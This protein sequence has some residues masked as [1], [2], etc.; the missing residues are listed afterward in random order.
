MPMQAYAWTMLNASSPW[1]VQFSSSGQYARHLVRF[2]LSGL[3]SA[4]DLTVKLDGK[5]L[6]WT[7]RLDIGIDR[8]HYDI[9]RQ[10]VLEDGLHELS[11]QL[12]NN[13][14]EGTAQLCS[15]EILEFGAPNEFISTPGHYSL[16]PTFSETNTTSY[17]PTNEDCLMRI[18]TTPN[19]CKVCL[20]GLW[21][22]LLRRVDFIDSISTSCDQ[23]GVSPPRFNRVLDLKLV[24]LGQFRL[25]ADDLEAGNK[26][27]AEEYS[28]TWY[29]DGEVLEE[30]VNQT[31]IE[32]NDG[33]GQ[34]VGL[35]S[36][37]VK[38]TTTENY[39]SL[40]NPGT[41]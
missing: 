31:H 4:S 34:G 27:P 37:E 26:I 22:S 33:D 9:H 7:P 24:P 20:E 5:D 39:R 13:Q 25:P 40:V 21:L 3:P 1:R 32:V 2:S 30:F 8:W 29:K 38:F 18:V 6:R 11:F 12:N 23:I 14:L 41:G 19:F 10:S 28:I 17:R 16:F 36:V 15:A 35:Y